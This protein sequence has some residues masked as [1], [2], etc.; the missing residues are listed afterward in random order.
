M[1]EKVI[2]PW[3]LFSETVRW[4]D[5]KSWTFFSRCGFAGTALFKLR[6]SWD[7]LCT[8]SPWPWAQWTLHRHELITTVLNQSTKPTGSNWIPI[9]RSIRRTGY[10]TIQTVKRPT[11][12]LSI[13]H[14]ILTTSTTRTKNFS[15]TVTKTDRRNNTITMVVKPLTPPAAWIWWTHAAWGVDGL[16]HIFSVA[17]IEG[18]LF[19]F[20]N[21]SRN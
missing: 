8:R 12:F 1:E 20:I 14:Q 17:A 9:K 2:T 11:S 19:G 10:D 5:R 4:L 16:A 7:S 21:W 3:P 18:F 13:R 15:V 6:N